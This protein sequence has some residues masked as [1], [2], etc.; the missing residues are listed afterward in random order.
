[1]VAIQ[2]QVSD[3]AANA[4]RLA[5]LRATL[6]PNDAAGEVTVTFGGARP[7][8]A[9]ALNADRIDLASLGVGTARGTA[10]GRAGSGDGRVFSDA[11]L[12]FDRLTQADLDLRLRVA[13]IDG[14]RVA[15]RNAAATIALHDGELA[16]QPWSVELGGGQAS[17]ELAASA[18]GALMLRAGLHGFNAGAL[19]REAQAT[20]KLDG[21]RG[22]LTLELRGTGRSLRAIMATANGSETLILRG[23]TVDNRF[24]ELIGADLVRWVGQMARGAE[25]PA[26]NCAIHR[27]DIHDGLATARVLMFDTSQITAA[28]EG[29]INLAS[30]ALALH[31]L[32]RPRD[33]SLLSLA[34]PLDIGG[35][36]AHPSFSPNAV[37]AIGRTATALGANVVLGPIGAVMSIANLGQ[38]R[39][40]PCITATA[41]AQGQAPRPAQGPGTGQGPAQAPAP[42][43]NPIGTIGSGIGRGIRGIFGR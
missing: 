6:G 11:P 17:G 12:P 21:G 24:F 26:L 36:L 5:N 15:L 19:L 10:G 23:G 34:V 16:V 22:D 35:T 18:R 41:L 27:F 3:S 8:L 4:I 2:A 30:E 25:R 7:A 14:F 40:D 42:S 39:E 13:R 31:V 9:G 37:G 43:Q 32:P 28:G 20:D 33:S 29:T 38:G 1:V